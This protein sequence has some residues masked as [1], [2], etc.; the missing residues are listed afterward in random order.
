LKRRTNEGEEE[1]KKSNRRGR[2]EE[3]KRKRHE[4]NVS[5]LQ[6]RDYKCVFLELNGN[7]II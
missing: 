7:M 1:L 4:V 2:E 5:K 6:R 3:E